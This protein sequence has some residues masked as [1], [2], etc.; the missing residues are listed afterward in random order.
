MMSSNKAT[1]MK[2]E[3]STNK[4]KFQTFWNKAE[5]HTQSFVEQ[6]YTYRDDAAKEAKQGRPPSGIPP[7]EM[8]DPF[9]N[10]PCLIEFMVSQSVTCRILQQVVALPDIL[11]TTEFDRNA[12]IMLF[13]MLSD[14]QLTHNHFGS[15]DVKPSDLSF[16]Y[17][18]ASRCDH[19]SNACPFSKLLPFEAASTKQREFYSAP[20]EP[21]SYLCR[22]IWMNSARI[23]YSNSADIK[24][25]LNPDWYYIRRATPCAILNPD[26]PH[27]PEHSLQLQ[28]TEL[29]SLELTGC[30]E[31]L[32]RTQTA[33]ADGFVT[34][35]KGEPTFYDGS[36][37]PLIL[38]YPSEASTCFDLLRSMYDPCH[39]SWCKGEEDAAP[40]HQHTYSWPWS[41]SD[42]SPKRKRARNT[43]AHTAAAP[44]D[45]NWDEVLKHAHNLPEEELQGIFDA[46]CNEL[47]D[48][49]TL[50]RVL[51]QHR[52]ALQ[53]ACG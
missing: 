31:G 40:L 33:P 29:I 38:P 49:D 22:C 43:H 9:T 24:D 51:Q 44:P 52:Q 16:C 35:I 50:L 37:T 4:K 41:T 2:V 30:A 42:L 10:F 25:C 8:E 27:H 23:Q 13:F 14:L 45:G 7:P 47:E 12:Q 39:V 15:G 28:T 20:L 53:E 48:I 46:I 26:A 6:I 1:A 36:T 5:S 34:V 17:I 11:G 18:C 21:Y 3:Q 32:H 19:T